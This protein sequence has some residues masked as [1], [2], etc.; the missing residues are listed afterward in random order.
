MDNQ[1]INDLLNDGIV[2][3]EPKSQENVGKNKVVPAY[4]KNKSNNNNEKKEK[5]TKKVKN[6][7]NRKVNKKK[8]ILIVVAIIVIVAVSILLYVLIQNKKYA[9]YE[10]YE[11]TMHTYAF[12][13]M[14]DNQSAATREKVTKS[15]A[16]KMVIAATLN[17][18]D[19]PGYIDTNTF[20]NEI[21]V[22][23]AVA[24]EIIEE[25]EINKDNA[26]DTV[27]YIE[28]ISYLEKAKVKLLEQELKTSVDLLFKDKDDYG[29][30]KQT[31]LQDLVNSEV[32]ENKKVKL[33][34]N[35]KIFKGQVNELITKYAEKNNTITL[36]GDKININPEKIPSNADMYPYTLSNVDKEVYEKDFFSIEGNEEFA[37]DP[38]TLYIQEK[39]YYDGVK[40]IIESFY[41]LLL[42]IDYKTI[43]ANKLYDELNEV[44][45]YE[46]DQE[47]IDEYV[48]YVKDNNIK[49][50]GQAKAQMPI[51]YYDG[52][53]YRVRTK[54]TI[55]VENTLKYENLIL[56]DLLSETPRTYQKENTI[57][58][59]A[60]LTPEVF[61]DGW[62]VYFS[63]ISENE[64]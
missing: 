35:K 20:P 29:V 2:P 53:Y 49:I 6:N 58:I 31:Y 28:F 11:E 32:L 3:D 10:P 1:D 38:K 23:F 44:T 52:S 26:N 13:I 59:D 62:N 18:T 25:N 36:E 57:I 63:N 37:I 16:I 34:G 56:G 8:I 4:E 55:N 48:K 50:S 27:T 24:N 40:Q 43:D 41:G 9:K 46:V 17:I 14:Y 39:E 47:I 22:K 30:D 5:K 64:K 51:I 42:N 61:S 60:P 12:D 54:L 15:E 7:S 21:W 33:K 45:A 19:I